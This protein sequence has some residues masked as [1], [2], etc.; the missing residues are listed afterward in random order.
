MG[1]SP[2]LVPH[3]EPDHLGDGGLVLAQRP[4]VRLF[5]EGGHVVVDVQDVDP[6]TPCCLLPAAVPG[7]DGQGVALRGLEVQPSRQQ[8]HTRVFVQ[9]ETGGE[10]GASPGD[11][12]LEM[13]IC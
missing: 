12:T 5:L 2:L 3:P 11:H 13:G 4:Q 6:G 10:R 1:T 8:D 7:N 9:G